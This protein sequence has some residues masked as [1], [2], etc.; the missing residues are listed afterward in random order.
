[1]QVLLAESDPT[2]ER[3]LVDWLVRESFAVTSAPTLDEV[4][5]AQVVVIGRVDGWDAICRR[6]R[7][8]HPAIRIVVLAASQDV[9]TALEAGADDVL[10]RD[11]LSLRELALRL[12]AVG[13]R[14]GVAPEKPV[15]FELG[16]LVI[17]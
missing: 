13:R 5:P 17:D 10:Q 6:L 1:M 3:S 9:V 4:D 12:R 16:A 8:E 11:G 2:L 14:K 7:R 15:S